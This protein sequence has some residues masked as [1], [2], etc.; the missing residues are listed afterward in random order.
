MD[1]FLPRHKL[2]A[3]PSV[4]EVLG[5][6]LGN[7]MLTNLIEPLLGGLHAGRVD[8]LS[9]AAVAPHILAMARKHR[10][11]ILG[12]RSLSQKTQKGQS[13]NA[14][15]PRLC[16]FT[17]GLDHLVQ[18]LQAHIQKVDLQL[19]TRLQTLKRQADG[20]YHLICSTG[21]ELIADSVV[22][23]VPAWEASRLLQDLDATSAKE[24]GAMEYASVMVTLL[25]YT[26]T[27][28]SSDQLPGNGFL[29]PR[30]DGHVMKACTWA[31][32]KWSRQST[33]GSIV[34]RCSAGRAGDERATQ[35]SDNELLETIQREL[36][37]ALHI[38]ER[39]LET[40][41]VPWKRAFP[42]YNVGHQEK[43]KQVEMRLA[44]HAPGLIL[45]GSAYHGIGLASC[46]KDGVFV[47]QHVLAHTE[48]NNFDSVQNG[49]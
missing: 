44:E 35:M 22:L 24:L 42:Q 19:G 28:L 39:P 18:R 40:L 8:N 2:S 12:L 21:E 15:P 31:T 36:G 25:S 17:D 48:S 32:K 46:V 4:K 30:A 13:K 38:Q 1:L 47:A 3:D 16:S 43:V 20:T 23:A 26:H 33:S 27:A 10:S 5:F 49:V 14:G 37:Q 41:V 7:D 34:L 45:A 6:R 9:I 11:L 29:V